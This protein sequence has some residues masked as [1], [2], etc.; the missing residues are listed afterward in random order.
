MAPATRIGIAARHHAA[1]PSPI[2]VVAW[3]CWPPS[4]RG[5]IDQ[6]LS[7]AVDVLMSIP[8]LDLR[9][10]AAVDLRHL[11]AQSRSSSSRSSTSTRVFRLVARRRDECRG[12]GFRRGGASC[13]AKGSAGSSLREILPNIMPPLV[14]E[15]GLRFCFV[16]LTICGAVLPRPRHPAAHRRLGLDGARER[17]ADHLW[18]FDAAASRPARSRC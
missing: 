1:C 17:D 4:A 14:A 9:A 8:Q 13:A 11:G 6:L 10:D 5:W 15:F 7:R 3:R 12:A 18:R 2:G 16:F